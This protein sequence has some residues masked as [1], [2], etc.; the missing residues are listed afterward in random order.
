[1]NRLSLVVNEIFQSIQGESSHAGIP[2]TFIRLTGCNLRC[3]YCDTTYA[4][5][6]GIEMSLETIIKQIE[7][8]GCKNVCI[9]GGEPLLQKSVPE[10]IR[11]LSLLDC[12]ICI[13]TNGS[14]DI[15]L[16]PK[17]T[18]RVMDI[19]CPDSLMHVEMDWNNIKKLRHDDEVKF[20][21]SSK[22]DYEWAKSIV[23]KNDLTHKSK[24]LFGVVY[25]RLEPKIVAELI[26]SD[27]LNVR[28]QLQLHKYIWPD[29][30]RGV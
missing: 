27:K 12:K 24:V 8:Y 13:E 11:Q 21:I 17:N 16:L 9:T 30:T 20:V 25:S 22:E 28:L 2:C 29:K 15:N 7:E 18:I 6:E 23:V 26:V 14:L 5:D 1:M 19:K 10:L 4:Y 3:S